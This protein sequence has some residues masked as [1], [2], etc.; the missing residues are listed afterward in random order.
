MAA[1]NALISSCGRGGRA[2]LSLALINEMESKFGAKPDHR[3]YRSAMIA[4]NQAQHEQVL[5]RAGGLV[6]EELGH[7]SWW[8]CAL[9]LWRRMKED[10]LAPDVQ[11]ISSVISACESAGQW[12]RA[13]GILQT[14]MDG[15]SNNKGLNLYCFNAAIS[16]C[17]KGGAWIEALDL[18]ERMMDQGGK[19]SPNFVTLNSLIVALDKAGQEELAQSKYE[20]A[21]RMKIVNPWRKTLD[22]RKE[23]ILAIVSSLIIFFSMS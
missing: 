3:S 12:Q 11:T 9:S 18:Y 13:L 21:R 6:N 4:C 8:E 20:E 15:N 16:A 7:I 19:I 5:Y 17:E 14:V 2:D 1:V 23:E 10:N 22:E